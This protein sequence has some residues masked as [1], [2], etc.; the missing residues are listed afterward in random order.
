MYIILE[1]N[2][3]LYLSG[4]KRNLRA[5]PRTPLFFI[6]L[7]ILGSCVP[8]SK[9]SYLN[10]I[11]ILQES[12]VN[13][14]EQKKIMPFDKLYI[15]VISIDEKTNQLFNAR[16]NSGGSFNTNLISNLVDEDGNINY[17]FAGKIKVGGLTTDEAG[18]KIEEALNEY[19]TNAA[20]TVKFL[21]NSISLLGEVQQQGNHTFTQDKLN[22]YEALSLGGGLTRYGDHRKVIL[23]REENKKIMYH[24]LNL[25]DTRIS[26][27][28]Y[29]YVLPNDVIV[30]EPLKNL[31]FSYG[32]N[33]YSIILN[34][35]TT[36]IA[37]LLF[38]KS[39]GL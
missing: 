18:H 19:V 2:Y 28:E 35:I 23:I 12:P 20:V 29:F 1:L 16:D 27:Q 10:D 26:G 13:P 14:R 21:D 5:M 7:L 4:M 36:L 9:L 15:K 8:V 31:S 33:T 3:D 32:N 34:S 17:P 11:D 6:F 30:V 37:I 24:K 39:F 38:G 25:S 22:I